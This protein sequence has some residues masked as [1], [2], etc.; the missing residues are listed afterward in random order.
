MRR[1]AVAY[2]KRGVVTIYGFGGAA[3]I[4]GLVRCG[5]VQPAAVVLYVLQF[6]DD[7]VMAAVNKA[8]LPY[9]AA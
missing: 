1:S 3:E 4:V 6:L 5:G 8:A 7:I 2:G 9:P